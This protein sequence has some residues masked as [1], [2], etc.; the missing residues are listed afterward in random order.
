MSDQQASPLGLFTSN[1]HLLILTI[2]MILVAGTSALISLPRI[3]DPRITTRNAIIVTPFPGASAARIEAL[4][5]K[6]IE[7]RLRELPEIKTI[8]STSR[9]G[10][11]VVRIELQDWVGQD[12][13][14]QIFSQVRDRLAA[15]ATDLPV[16]AGTPAFDDM[17][18]AVAYSMIFALTWRDPIHS[19]LGILNRVAEKLGDRLR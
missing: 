11:S 1:R 6:K 8:Q 17:R 5:T 15:A 16:G 18:G 19:E 2:V 10:I 13:N 12:D 4:V 9:S 3:E 7:D 14:E